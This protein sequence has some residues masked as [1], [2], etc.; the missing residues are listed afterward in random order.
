MKKRVT[1]LFVDDDQAMLNAIQRAFLDEPFDMYFATSGR[2][3]LTLFDK[4]SF[5]IVV[6]DVRMPGMDGQALL[7]TIKEQHPEI[8]RIL[9]SGQ[10]TLKQEEISTLVKTLKQG[11]IF[12]FLGKTIHMNT[13][14]KNVIYEA[15]ESH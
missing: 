11:D 8:I 14:L 4:H 12:K 3:A 2:E 6:S 9:F 13:D 10:P 1:I 5:D 7:N 15:M